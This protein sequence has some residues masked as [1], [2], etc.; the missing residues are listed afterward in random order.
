MLI[1]IS[2][3]IDR[4]TINRYKQGLISIKI[5]WYKGLY[6]WRTYRYGIYLYKTLYT[7]IIYHITFVLV[8][9]IFSSQRFAR[10]EDFLLNWC[11]DRIFVTLRKSSETN[12]T[13]HRLLPVIRSIYCRFSLPEKSIIRS[14]VVRCCLL[15]N[16]CRPKPSPGTTEKASIGGMPLNGM[17]VL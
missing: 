14:E 15:G 6:R 4:A 10:L 3:Y 11:I 16:K 7:Y 9:S 12:L 8:G 17:A 2:L 5:N 1:D 13:W